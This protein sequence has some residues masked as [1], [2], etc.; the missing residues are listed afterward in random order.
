MRRTGKFGKGR[1]GRSGRRR[2]IPK[3]KRCFFCGAGTASL[4]YKN[5]DLLSRYVSDR[6]RIQPGRKT[7]VCVKHQRSLS[8]ALKRGRHLALLP[9]TS[10]HFRRGAAVHAE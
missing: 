7:G 9:Y 5:V 1:G 4:D 3:R 10:G 6:G 2:Y 8:V